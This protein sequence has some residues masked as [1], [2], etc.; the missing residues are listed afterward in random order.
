MSDINQVGA[1][2]KLDNKRLEDI[3]N[4]LLASGLPEEIKEQVVDLL[5]LLSGGIQPDELSSLKGL[6]SELLDILI[7]YFPNILEDVKRELRDM[8]EEVMKKTVESKIDEQWLEK[9]Q[10]KVDK[11]IEDF[12]EH[13]LNTIADLL[14]AA[15]KLA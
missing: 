14:S 15:D 10:H 8:L 2:K 1:S 12:T 3:K 11:I 5:T 9:I 6:L 7:K 13:N 4:S